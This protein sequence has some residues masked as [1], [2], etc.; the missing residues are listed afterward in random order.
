MQ[1]DRIRRLF[2]G[3][4]GKVVVIAPFIKAAA[5]RSLLEVLSHEVHVRCVTRW[6]TRE[7]AAGVSDPEIVDVLEEHGH[8]S[9]CLV[10]RLHA[11]IYMAG[12]RCL[13]GSSNV[14]FAGLGGGAGQANI[15]VLVETGADDPG[16]VATLE[17]VAGAERPATRAMAEDVRRLADSVVIKEGEVVDLEG[18]WFPRSR[19]PEQAFRF[20]S[21][22]PAGFVGAADRIL[23]E[24]LGNAN[25][26]PGLG[27][28]EFRTEM[29][30]RLAGIAIAQRVLG[31]QE[32]V[33]LRYSDARFFLEGIAV[34]EYSSKDL[35]L[36]FVGWMAWF[37]SEEI[38]VQEITDV[39]LRRAQ[40]LSS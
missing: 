37:F 4:T 29:R 40:L 24:D 28:G 31:A 16:V 33:T 35:W 36:A 17:E 22:P 8:F 6:L 25:L 26:A 13:C 23:L 34:E 3:A 9:L 15:E 20:Y 7:V 14:T 2:G 38:I 21:R 30:E 27:E 11:K 5:L 32:D 19:K 10:D 1:G 39:G 18:P 12:G